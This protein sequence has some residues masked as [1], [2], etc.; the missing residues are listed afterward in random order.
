VT[1]LQF[2][3]SLVSTVISWPL[4]FAGAILLFRRPLGDLIRRA[5]SYEGMGQKITFGEQLAGA[6]SSVQEALRTVPADTK[7]TIAPSPSL[8]SATLGRDAEA[9]PSL[10]VMQSWQELASAVGG[11]ADSV[12][13]AGDSPPRSNSSSDGLLR[14]L[15][16]CGVV[17]PQFVKAT[18]DLRELRDRV[19]HGQHTPTAGEAL[20]YA[21]SAQELSLA[22]RVL[23]ASVEDVISP[24]DSA[25]IRQ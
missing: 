9:A 1:G 3:S 24:S 21:T 17:S 18:S 12:R 13:G 20:A 14:E 5:R 7:I 10:V 19:A 25:P 11:L 8:R 4:A 16:R 23:S 22:A 2:A 15:E 6:E